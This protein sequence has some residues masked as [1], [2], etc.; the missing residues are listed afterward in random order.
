MS[1]ITHGGDN[2]V[3]DEVGSNSGRKARKLAKFKKLLTNNRTT[4]KLI[5]LILKD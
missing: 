1:K 3:V 4:K 2:E 5:F